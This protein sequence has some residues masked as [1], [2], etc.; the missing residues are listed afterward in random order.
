MY[1]I[2]FYWFKNGLMEYYIFTLTNNNMFNN[3]FIIKT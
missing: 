3:N 1:A 2:L